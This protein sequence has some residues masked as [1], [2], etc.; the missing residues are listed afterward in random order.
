MDIPKVCSAPLDPT[1]PSLLTLPADIRNSINE[2]IFIRPEPILIHDTD[3]YYNRGRYGCDNDGHLLFPEQAFDSDEEEQMH[4]SKKKPCSKSLKGWETR[5]DAEKEDI[6]L[7]QHEASLGIGLLKSCRQMYHE[8]S[9]VFYS[10]NTFIVSRVRDRAPG[11]GRK[12]CESGNRRDYHQLSYT[13][14]WLASLGSQVRRLK[15]IG[16]RY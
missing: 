2:Y 8:T 11:G 12:T 10:K 3:F 4:Q 7:F 16:Y 15:K 5:S 6:L 1:A 9:S 13:P 14:K